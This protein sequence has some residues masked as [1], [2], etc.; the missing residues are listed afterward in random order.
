[1]AGSQ[2]EAVAET[3]RETVFVQGP[4]RSST[5][6]IH[7]FGPHE[8]SLAFSHR[9]LKRQKEVTVLQRISV[10]NT[11]VVLLVT[12]AF[13][14][15]GLRDGAHCEDLR[16]MPLLGSHLSPTAHGQATAYRYRGGGGGGGQPGLL[17]LTRPPTHIRGDFPQEKNGIYQRGPKLEVDFIFTTFFLASRPPPPSRSQS[18]LS[19]DLLMGRPSLQG[20]KAPRPILSQL[21]DPHTVTCG[22]SRVVVL[23][24][25]P[26]RQH[27]QAT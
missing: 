13:S 20:N 19:R 17:R 24:T 25:L 14:T 3:V 7:D 11:G 12:T 26:D 27:R 22:L 6:N 18:P 5:T 9:A 15:E 8:H 10:A 16:A 23:V 2:K 1:M 4:P 21:S